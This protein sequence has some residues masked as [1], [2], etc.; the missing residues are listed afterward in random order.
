M[1]SNNLRHNVHIKVTGRELAKLFQFGLQIVYLNIHLL[2]IKLFI[3]WF[4]N[5]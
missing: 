4:V 1:T 5:L 2:F 3:V